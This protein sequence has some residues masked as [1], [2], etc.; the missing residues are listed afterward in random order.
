MKY[1]Y[2][3]YQKPIKKEMC[4]RVINYGDPIQS[5]AVKNLYREMGIKEEDIIPVPRYDI[6]NYDGEECVCVVN[7]ASIYEEQTYDVHFMPPSSKIHAIPMSMHIH[8]P[9]PKDELE[10]YRTCGGVG[11]RDVSTMHRL[12]ELGIQAY[13]TGCLTITLPR[14]N[15]IQEKNAD[16]IYLIEVPDEVMDYM[17]ECI[18]KEGIELSN[19]ARYQSGGGVERMSVEETYEFHEAAEKRIELLRDTAK[20]VV[21]SRLHIASPCLAMGIPVILTMGHLGER[22]GYID[23]LMPLY[24]QEQY[25]NI[26]WNPKPV[27]FEDI[28]KIIKDYFFDKV[29][30]EVRRIELEKMWDGLKPVCNVDYRTK[31]SIIIS[32]LSLPKEHF[33]Y[34]VWGI[35]LPSAYSF[36]EDM[37]KQIPQSELVAGI[38]ISVTGLFCEKEIIKPEEIRNMGEKV[39]IFVVA[40][41]A[42]EQA[43]AILGELNRSYVLIKGTKFEMY[44]I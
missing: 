7:C 3:F 20:L 21:T 33:K 36:V 29:R 25:A 10:Y 30:S 38:D 39:I 19:I 16:K 13:L 35:A 1:G 23:R 2:M 8:R 42:Q 34:A 4:S 31:T 41:S 43:K 12:Q 6:A 18:K 32:Q 15:F 24:S 11:C 26:D 37:K 17:P 9:L 5:Y 22:F 14:R 44:N 28:K 27:Y 40:P